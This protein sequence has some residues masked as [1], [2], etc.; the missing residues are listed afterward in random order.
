MNM[1]VSWGTGCW[2]LKEDMLKAYINLG[3]H[4]PTL[5]CFRELSECLVPDVLVD[6]ENKIDLC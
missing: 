4:D 5:Y 3:E 6:H 2:H 1:Q